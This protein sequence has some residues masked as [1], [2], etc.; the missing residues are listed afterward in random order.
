[1]DA[2]KIAGSWWITG[3]VAAGAVIALA[4]LVAYG[5]KIRAFFGEVWVELQKCSWPWDPQQEGVKKYKELI[6]STVVVIVS[7]I[8]L[9]AFVTASDFVLVKVI[10]FVTRFH[11]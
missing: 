3:L 10:G 7:T 5:A 2:L 4:V 1:M 11:N 8:L 9:G 6:D